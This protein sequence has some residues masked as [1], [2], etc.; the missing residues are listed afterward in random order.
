MDMC[1]VCCM[2]TS[3]R[4]WGW[5]ENL[6]ARGF[7]TLWDSF[8]PCSHDPFELSPKKQID[9]LYVCVFVTLIH[10]YNHDTCRQNH[11]NNLKKRIQFLAGV[12]DI[13]TN[14]LCEFRHHLVQEYIFQEKWWRVEKYRD[15]LWDVPSLIGSIPDR[16][17]ERKFY[18]ESIDNHM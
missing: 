11:D 14:H 7:L 13:W 8:S 16:K 6:L 2:D 15:V 1:C 12:L 4:R 3:F 17:K 5:E 10:R 18:W 9:L